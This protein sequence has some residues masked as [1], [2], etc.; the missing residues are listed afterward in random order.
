MFFNLFNNNKKVVKSQK[1]L[2]AIALDFDGVIEIR[3][4]T[5]WEPAIVKQKYKARV[6]ARENSSVEAWENSSVV[7]RENS[8]VVAWGNSSVEARENSSVV[9]WENSSVVAW[10]N[11]SVVARENSSVVAWGNSSVEAWENSSVVAWENSSVEAWENSSVVAW[12][13]SSVVAWEN[14]SVEARENSSV[15]ARGNVQVVNCLAPS[16]GKIKIS[17]NA[18][19]VYMPKNIHEFLDFYGVEH[20]DGKAI[21]Y[22]AVHKKDNTYFSDYKSAFTY[23]IGKEMIHEC[24]PN[25]SANCSFGL[26]I[27]HLHW[28]LTYGRNWRDL[29]ILEVEVDIKDIILPTNS[30]GKVRTSKMKVLREKPLSEC[31][32]YGKMLEKRL[33]NAAK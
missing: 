3:F 24:D 9:A 30:D 6:V 2:D 1:E 33:E 31:G 26:H 15:V 12:G 29:A 5:G 4:G 11:S 16:Y 25:V 23:N 18:R 8:S 14:S 27:A 7:A 19:I 28:A 22:K 10:E 21:F 13:N 20:S 32:V 17:G